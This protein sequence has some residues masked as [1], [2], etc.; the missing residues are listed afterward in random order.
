MFKLK[1][2]FIGLMVLVLVPNCSK[3]PTAPDTT[4]PRDLTSAEKSI[5]DSDNKFGLKLFRE[6]NEEEGAKN[7]FISPLS[8]SFALGMTM[9]GAN[10]DTY[11][12]MK[13]TLEFAGLTEEQINKSYRDLM[14]LLLNLDPKVVFQIAN[15]IWYK[16]SYTFKQSFF[17]V[18]KEYFD[19]EVSGLNFSD[20]ASVNIINGWVEQNTNGK[21]KQIINQIDPDVVMFLINAIYF[22]GMWTFQFEE[23]NTQDDY[24]T[25]PDNS[26]QSCRMMGQSNDFSYF[27]DDK[28][29]AID[30]PYGDGMF[31]MVVVLPKPEVNVDDLI[32]ELNQEAWN[33][34]LGQFE[35]QQG[36]VYLPRFKLEYSIQMN[37]ALKALG[38]GIAFSDRADFTNIYEPGGLFISNVIHKSFVEVNEEGTEAS[39]VT[40]VQVSWTSVGD[41]NDGF[42]MKVNRPFIFAI[43]DNHSDSIIFIGKIVNPNPQ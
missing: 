37:D 31:S 10:G 14:E 28:V 30:L 32:G 41:H 8:V 29:Q 36:T 40:L 18:S 1:S 26:T 23:E 34:W 6:V 3:S 27:S 24:F 22:K 4:L 9:N 15:S 38:M 12:A 7:I 5:V 39:A 16:N 25:L 20:P 33:G 11:D 43:R 2:I 17:D 13:S 21:I 42:Y 19:A 35:K